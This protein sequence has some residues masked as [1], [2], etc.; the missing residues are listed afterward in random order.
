[1]TVTIE[2]PDADGIGEIVVASPAGFSGYLGEP[3]RAAGA[4]VR[5]GDLGR[6]DAAGRL[7]VIDRRTD[8]IV[9]GGENI[10]PAEIEAALLAHPAVADAAVV[11]A[12]NSLWG[13]VPVAALVLRCGQ[14]DPGDAAL[15]A[16]CRSILAGFKVPAA[17]LRLD[18]LPRTMGGKL[19]RETVRALVDGSPA[20]ELARPA[21]DRIGWRVTGST[22]PD[23]LPL[24]LLPGTLSTAAQLDRLAGNLARAGDVTVHAVDRRGS[25]SSRRA[26]DGPLDVGTHVDDLAAYLDARDLGSAVIVGSSFGGV[27][28]LELAARRPDRARAVV[29]YEPPYGPLADAATQARFAATAART[30]AAHAAGGAAAAAEAFLR[31]VSGDAAWEA[32]SD[33]SRAF[34]A[35]EGDAALAD[36]QLAGLEPAGLSR[37]TAPALI[38]SGGASHDFYR[39]IAEALVARIPGARQATL[40]GLTHNAPITDAV[41]VAEAIRTFLAGAGLLAAPGTGAPASVE[42]AP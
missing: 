15:T 20:G 35:R 24:I 8:R 11:A 5:T 21:G 29:A 9:R 14:P 38:L 16:H 12:P 7:F 3:P 31:A 1:V 23:S 26:S 4:P 34:I 30:A 27:L 6:L 18:A 39:P 32:L 42:I 13:Q 25:G 19:Q 41:R 37:I 36:S 17:F 10:A 2:E 40:D 33:R 22:E 28:A